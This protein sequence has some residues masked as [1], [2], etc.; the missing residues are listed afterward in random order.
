MKSLSV[1]VKKA[2]KRVN[3]IPEIQ[4]RKKIS[5]SLQN[6]GTQNN[7]DTCTAIRS[8]GDH[9]VTETW[10]K[11]VSWPLIGFIKNPGLIKSLK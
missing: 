8:S 2:L 6:K 11:S 7:P 10:P 3:L 9:Q 5:Q 1:W 4:N